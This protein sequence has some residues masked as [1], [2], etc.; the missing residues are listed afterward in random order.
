MQ[1]SIWGVRAYLDQFSSM[2]PDIDAWFQGWLPEVSSGSRAIYAVRRRGV[3]DG[4]AITKGHVR[5][6]LCHFS[7][8]PS[9][10]NHRLGSILS[11]VVLSDLVGA[12]AQSV[13]VTTGED[14]YRAAGSF[15]RRVGFV[16]R[17]YE[18]SR[19]RKG[20]AEV[21]WEALLGNSGLMPYRSPEV[22]TADQEIWRLSSDG[23]SVWGAG[24]WSR[25]APP[26]HRCSS[27]LDGPW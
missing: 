26:L 5:V 17:G 15:F 9:A 23:M 3:L 19:Y 10:R 11:R 22:L 27:P 13:Y 24:T 16:P 20:V 18:V 12:G 8:N 25:M 2:Y 7:V 1:H 6:K 14:T 21:F 4:L